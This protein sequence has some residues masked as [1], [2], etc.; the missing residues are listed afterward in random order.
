M[1]LLV[2]SEISAP[3]RVVLLFLSCAAAEQ[4]DEDTEGYL[5]CVSL[6]ERWELRGQERKEHPQSGLCP[7]TWLLYTWSPLASF[8]DFL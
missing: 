1:F 3:E 7:R 6:E 5:P 4:A 8:F 2:L